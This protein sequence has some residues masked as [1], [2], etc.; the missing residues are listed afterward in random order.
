[1]SNV[2]KILYYTSLDINRK[3]GK[4]TLIQL[5]PAGKRYAIDIITNTS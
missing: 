1:M 4:K 3:I 5:Q 2:W